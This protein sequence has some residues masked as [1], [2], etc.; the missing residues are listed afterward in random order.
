MSL[1]NVLMPLF[2][3]TVTVYGTIMV[4]KLNKVQKSMTTN[5]GSKSLGDAIDIIRTKVDVMSDNQDDLISTMKQL[6]QRDQSFDQRLRHVED[7][8]IKTQEAVTGSIRVVRHP[9]RLHKKRKI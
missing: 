6:H 2:V 7:I 3:A 4:A 1:I 5:H 8:T 9:V